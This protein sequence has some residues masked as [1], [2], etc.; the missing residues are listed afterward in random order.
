MG[1]ARFTWLREK[2]GVGRW[3]LLLPPRE[4]GAALPG[5]RPGSRSG[6]E[7]GRARGRDPLAEERQRAGSE[8]AG[9]PR[10]EARGR[11]KGV[12]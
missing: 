7:R 10:G 5:G 9:R 3:L 2:R 8:G 6:A 12:E 1:V 11:G 4:L